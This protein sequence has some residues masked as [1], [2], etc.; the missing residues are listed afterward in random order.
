MMLFLLS[1]MPFLGLLLMTSDLHGV[2]V[3]REVYFELVS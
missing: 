3:R 2:V 1:G